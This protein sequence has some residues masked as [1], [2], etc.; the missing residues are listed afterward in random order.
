MFLGRTS[1]VYTAAKGANIYT[2][3]EDMETGICLCWEEY[4]IV[5]D[6]KMPTG[7]KIFRCTEFAVESIPS[8]RTL[9]EE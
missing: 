3:I 8:L 2:Y 9:I 7:N 5:E 1:Y 4:S 6:Q